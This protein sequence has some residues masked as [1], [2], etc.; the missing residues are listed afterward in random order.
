MNS[1]YQ[2]KNYNQIFGTVPLKGDVLIQSLNYAMEAGCRAIDTAQ[3]YQNESD[4]GTFLQQTS[5][6]REDLCITTKVHPHNFDEDKF[7]PSVK[8]SLQKLGLDSVDCLLVH[9]PFGDDNTKPLERLQ[10]AH[11]LGLTKHIGVSNYTITMLEHAQQVLESPIACNQVEFHPLID[12]SK[13]L[14]AANDM[15]ILLTAYCPVARGKALQ[16]DII[17]D[18]AGEVGKASGQVIL[19][20]ILQKGVAFQAMSQNPVNIKN[21][22]DLDDFTL[23]AEQM[24]RIDTLGALNQ[25]VSGEFKLAWDTPDWD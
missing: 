6:P 17:Q 4:V 1:I 11:D 9:W 7:I 20:W 5:I 3:M 18:I 23:S 10:Q 15:G 19:K 8:D 13:L 16:Q 12:Q 14:Q 24:Q 22:Y 25:R 21:N 2:Q